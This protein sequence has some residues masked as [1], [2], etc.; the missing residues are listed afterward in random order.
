[1][2]PFIYRNRYYSRINFGN[3]SKELSSLT[4]AILTHSASQL[5]EYSYLEKDF[6]SQA[7]LFADE[8]ES[9]E[10]GTKIASIEAL[11]ACV[12]LVV[13]ELKIGLSTRAWITTGKAIRLAQMLSLHRIDVNQPLNHASSFDSGIFGNAGE[14]EEQRRTFWAAYILDCFGAIERHIPTTI[15]QSE[16]R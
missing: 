9:L 3:P 8:T 16:V 4:Y 2:F 14:L 13:Y 7:R 6:Y 11:Q 12:L 1:M 5:S 10:A 15:A